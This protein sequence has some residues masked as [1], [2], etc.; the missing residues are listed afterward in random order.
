M[1]KNKRTISVYFF[2]K[3]N[4]PPNRRTFSAY[5]L[6]KQPVFHI[7]SEIA[8]NLPLKSPVFGFIGCL[9]GI[10]P[11]ISPPT[12]T[13]S[14][15]TVSSHYPSTLKTKKELPLLETTLQKPL[16]LLQ[17]LHQLIRNLPNIPG[18]H[19]NNNIPGFGIL[20]QKGKNIIF[21]WLIYYVFIRILFNHIY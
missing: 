7:F 15:S 13:S 11:L 8:G 19:C 17:P 10:P 20:G 9:N 4:L 5:R 18:P 14:P 6:K 12:P 3:T 1:E 16:F 21:T 2:F